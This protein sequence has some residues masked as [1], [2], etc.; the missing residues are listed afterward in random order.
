MPMIQ[1]ASFMFL[2]VVQYNRSNV[3]RLL[4]LPLVLGLP[5]VG[6]EADRFPTGNAILCSVN[7]RNVARETQAT[8]CTYK[9]L[10]EKNQYIGFFSSFYVKSSEIYYL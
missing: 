10:P 3:V 8:L 6:L 1:T 7:G 5:P 2:K 9:L 4:L